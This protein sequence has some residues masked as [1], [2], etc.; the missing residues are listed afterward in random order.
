MRIKLTVCV[1]GVLL[2]V[3]AALAPVM[4]HA[5]EICHQAYLSCLTQADS[6]LDDC[7]DAAG[8]NSGAIE[9]CWDEY[10]VDHDECFHNYLTCIWTIDF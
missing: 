1:L 8:N 6:V 2:V 10:W 4:M 7:L 9:E 3:A 5:F